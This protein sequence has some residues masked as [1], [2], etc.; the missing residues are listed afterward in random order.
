MLRGACTSASARAAAAQAESEATAAAAAA[1]AAEALAASACLLEASAAEAAA[2]EA[3]T[4]LTASLADARTVTLS[5]IESLRE[6]GSTQLV[7]M[8]SSFAASLESALEAQPPPQPTPPETQEAIVNTEPSRATERRSDGATSGNAAHPP[9]AAAPPSALEE[10]FMRRSASPALGSPDAKPTWGQFGISLSSLLAPVAGS[11]QRRAGAVYSRLESESAIRPTAPSSAAVA[12]ESPQASNLQRQPRPLA[13]PPASSSDVVAATVSP[14]RPPEAPVQ[15]MD[16]PEA[17]SRPSTAAPPDGNVGAAQR[18]RISAA[19]ISTQDASA[20][21]DAAVSAAIQKVIE[22]RKAAALG[23]AGPAS[24]AR[25]RLEISAS[26]SPLPSSPTQTAQAVAARRRAQAGDTEPFQRG[27]PE[28]HE[29]LA[30]P[31]HPPLVP[32]PPPPLPPQS[33]LPPPPPDIDIARTTTDALASDAEG[34]DAD[35]E[36]EEGSWLDTLTGGAWTAL[37]IGDGAEEEQG[38]GSLLRRGRHRDGLEGP[39]EDYWAD[40]R[41]ARTPA[42]APPMLRSPCGGAG[43]SKAN[44]DWGRTC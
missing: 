29:L 28:R 42:H 21:A 10:V 32:P 23:G 39:D 26:S 4:V 13:E 27:S 1:A 25:L 30:S 11:P 33:P 9:A 18:G 2:S 44:K 24:S 3:V 17:P 36:E 34:D 35:A 6:T 12:A 19:D 5:S 15:T 31:A 20:L 37:F 40:Y 7:D 14:V 41:P 22:T 16:E 43:S 8:L 38:G